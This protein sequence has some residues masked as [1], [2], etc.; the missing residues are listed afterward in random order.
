MSQ[1]QPRQ[2]YWDKVREAF[3]RKHGRDMEFADVARMWGGG[4]VGQSQDSGQRNPCS[5][6]SDDG[7]IDQ[8]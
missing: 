5:R 4:P 3:R 2:K 6:S 8:S 1:K 7:I